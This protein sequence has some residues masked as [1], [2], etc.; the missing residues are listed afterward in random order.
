MSNTDSDGGGNDYDRLN[1]DNDNPVMGAGLPAP[2]STLVGSND[3]FGGTPYQDCDGV[4]D[5]SDTIATEYFYAGSSDF[6]DIL[7]LGMT[8]DVPE[9]VHGE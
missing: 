7:R 4:N 3:G 6:H 8:L 2:M 5:C 9:G 1:H